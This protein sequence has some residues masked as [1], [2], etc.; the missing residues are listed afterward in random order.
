MCRARVP[1]MRKRPGKRL[2]ARLA[3]LKRDTEE[4]VPKVTLLYAVT[5]WILKEA[6]CLELE[7]FCS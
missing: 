7:Y 3:S 2:H 1:Q 6:V 4:K 5:F